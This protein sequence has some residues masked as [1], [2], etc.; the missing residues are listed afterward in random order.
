MVHR[1][2]H[3]TDNAQHGLLTEI[4]CH[5]I[6]MER[7]ERAEERLRTQREHHRARR[8]L[9]EVDGFTSDNP[10]FV[11]ALTSHVNFQF[12]RFI[13]LVHIILYRQ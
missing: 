11:L 5:V 3:D 9:D 8:V 4:I 12:K 6:A 1:V 13:T 10:F 2:N 7:E